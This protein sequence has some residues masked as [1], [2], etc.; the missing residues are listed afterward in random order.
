[1]S[2]PRTALIV[3][4]GKF[5]RH[6]VRIL[7]RLE[8]AIMPKAVAFHRLI[9]TR[10]SLEPARKTA[11]ALAKDAPDGVVIIGEQVDNEDD[12]NRILERYQPDFTCIVAKDPK[13]GN[14]IHAGT[15]FGPWQPVS[16][17]FVRN[18]LVKLTEPAAV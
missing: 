1:M 11:S 12:L 4:T 9:L 3:G 13:R 6:Y 7:S 10:T 2:K 14:R 17:C 18:R 8:N 5:G 16:M 15:V